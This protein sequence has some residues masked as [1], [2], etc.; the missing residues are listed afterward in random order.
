MDRAAYVVS[1]RPS[2]IV[3]VAL[4][5]R[6]RVRPRSAFRPLSQEA[7]LVCP[8]LVPAKRVEVRKRAAER[9]LSLVEDRR[10]AT[11]IFLARLSCGDRGKDRRGAEHDNSRGGPAEGP[12]VP[13]AVHRRLSDRIANE[14]ASLRIVIVSKPR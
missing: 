10:V 2:A 11:E 13:P 5:A 7:L 3:I 9:G 8:E 1:A 4:G 14:G 12:R 6:D